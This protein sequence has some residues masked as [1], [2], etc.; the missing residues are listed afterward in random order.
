MDIFK[1]V[2]PIFGFVACPLYPLKRTGSCPQASPLWANFC[3][4]HSQQKQLAF[5]PSDRS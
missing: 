1:I 5:S 2:P 4:T 3:R